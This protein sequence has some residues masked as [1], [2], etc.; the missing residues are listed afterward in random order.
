MN[1]HWVIIEKSQVPK[2][3]NI[4]PAVWAMR[5]KRDLITGKILKYKAR[6]NV[7]GGKQIYGL[8]YFET[9]SPVATWV[10]IRFILI[11]S[12]TLKWN[13]KQIDFIMAFP[14][15]DIEHDMYMSLP[16][17]I[18]PTDPS[19]DYILLLRKNLYGQKQA[20]RVFYLYLKEG[21]MKIGFQPSK[22]DE[23]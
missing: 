5:R 7:H 18:V 12:I 21:L 14:Q 17:G 4:L 15:A 22:I 9:Y 20:S 6:F 10:V 1:K 11:L 8:D 3:K 2:G 16:A 19:K 13:S 23:C